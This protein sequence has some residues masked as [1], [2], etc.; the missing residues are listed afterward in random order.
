MVNVEEITATKSSQFT[1]KKYNYRSTPSIV[2]TEMRKQGAKMLTQKT[3]SKTGTN[4]K[5][6]TGKNTTLDTLYSVTL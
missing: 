4:R 3:T 5:Q 2:V 1:P 6:N